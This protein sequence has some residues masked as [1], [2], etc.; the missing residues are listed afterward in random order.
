MNL[1]LKNVQVEITDFNLENQLS[2]FEMK[3]VLLLHQNYL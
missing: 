1:L 3:K 2:K